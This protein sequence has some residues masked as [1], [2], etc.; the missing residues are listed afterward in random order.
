MSGGQVDDGRRPAANGIVPGRHQLAP[1]LVEVAELE[2]A[3][4]DVGRH[5]GGGSRRVGEAFGATSRWY[6]SIAASSS[7]SVRSWFP[8]FHAVSIVSTGWSRT[9]ATRHARSMSTPPAASSPRSQRASPA[10]RAAFAQR[11]PD[12]LLL[13]DLQRGGGGL[14]DIVEPQR[15][16]RR[17][18]DADVV[19]ARRPIAPVGEHRLGRGEV[20]QGLVDVE[21]RPRTDGDEVG[22]ELGVHLRRSRRVAVALVQL[23]RVGSGAGGGTRVAAGEEPQARQPLEEAGAAKLV[24][25]SSQPGERGRRRFELGGRLI[26]GE[27][28]G[29]LVAGADRPLDGVVGITGDAGLAVVRR[30]DAGA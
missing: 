2:S 27:D 7:S 29:R 19:V 15:S 26:E 16:H 17:V 1:D 25:C 6:Q 28:A 30:P 4:V 11:P 13:R 3:P 14:L 12:A 10:S 9:S 18:G 24:G 23:E 21:A 22:A 8:R 20:A 5:D